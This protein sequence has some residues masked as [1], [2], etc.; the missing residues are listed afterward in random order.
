MFAGWTVENGHRRA[1]PDRVDGPRDVNRRGSSGRGVRTSGSSRTH[2]RDYNRR[3]TAATPFEFTGP[4]RGSDLLKTSVDPAG[5]TP[6]GTLSNCA[7]GVTPWGTVLSGEE[8][9]DQYFGAA[10]GLP[11]LYAAS[12]DRYGFA[13][14]RSR[15]WMGGRRPAFRPDRRTHRGSPVRV[16]RR[17]GPHRPDIHPAQAHIA[18]PVQAR[19]RD[20]LHR[21]GRPRGRLHGR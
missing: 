7:G 2:R 14:E 6:L 16:D 8:N 1:A 13:A 9:V 18:R 11:A 20:H 5:T 4:A 21:Q 12:Y 10:A 17:G 15:A 3:I 19:G